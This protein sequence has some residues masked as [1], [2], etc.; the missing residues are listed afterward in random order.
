[1]PFI[2]RLLV[3]DDDEFNHLYFILNKRFNLL[4]SMYD[5]NKFNTLSIINVIISQHL[6]CELELYDCENIKISNGG[7]LEI[8]DG[9][10]KS[11]QK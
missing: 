10:Q 9:G 4:P 3:S 2:Q 7:H 6:L 8:Q 1:M 5:Y 11:S